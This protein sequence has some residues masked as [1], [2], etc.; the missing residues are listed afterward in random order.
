MF[1]VLV[2]IAPPQL[3]HAV[4]LERDHP[5]PNLEHPLPNGIRVS[6]MWEGG[7]NHAK[8]TPQMINWPKAELLARRT[9]STASPSNPPAPKAKEVC[10]HNEH[11]RIP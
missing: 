3:S 9:H 6:N 2:R 7:D 5:T 8:L 11:K 4:S 10:W 1:R